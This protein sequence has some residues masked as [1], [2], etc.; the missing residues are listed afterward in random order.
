MEYDRQ[1]VG[2]VLKHEQFV[3]LCP[4]SVYFG[5]KLKFLEYYYLADPI[6]NENFIIFLTK[7]KKKIKIV[8]V[9]I[10]VYPFKIF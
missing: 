5:R 6:Q 10:P 8:L 7:K 3:E 4:W 9:K 2:G 1:T